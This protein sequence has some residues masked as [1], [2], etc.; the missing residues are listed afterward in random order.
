MSWSLVQKLVEG[1]GQHSTLVGK[2]WITT[3][4]IL[5]FLIVIAIA[6]STWGDAGKFTCNT[7]SPGCKNVCFN[8]FNP[9]TPIR[10]WMFQLLGVSL[11]SIIFNVYT[12]HKMALVKKAIEVKK[13][14]EAKKTS[15]PGRENS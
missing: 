4:F 8:V 6:K 9:I 14:K 1:A 5:R 2:F 13:E 10:W 12:T 11:V 15:G 3:F 7:Q